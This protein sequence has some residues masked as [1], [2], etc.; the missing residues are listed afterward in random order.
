MGLAWKTNPLEDDVPTKPG[1]CP[2]QVPPGES[3]LT[4]EELRGYASNIERTIDS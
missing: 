2:T 1:V 3:P 4:M